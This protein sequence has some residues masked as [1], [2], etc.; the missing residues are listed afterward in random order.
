MSGATAVV[1][2]DGSIVVGGDSD[3]CFNFFAMRFCPRAWAWQAIARLPADRAR[4]CVALATPD[5]E[6]LLGLGGFVGQK[7]CQV[8]GDN[9]CALVDELA[10]G[11]WEARPDLPCGM[12]EPV[13]LHAHKSDEDCGTTLAFWRADDDSIASENVVP[14]TPGGEVCISEVPG[15]ES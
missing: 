14:L 3:S 8:E 13:V 5:G 15:G 10:G 2:R 11:R 4:R 9:A 6:R 1:L 7:G 12:I